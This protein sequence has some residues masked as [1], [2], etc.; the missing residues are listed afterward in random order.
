MP[1]NI[2]VLTMT[3][4][5]HD[6]ILGQV[7]GLSVGSVPPALHCVVSMGDRDLT[8]GRLPLATDRWET[9]VRPVPTDRRALPYAAARN[10]AAKEAIERGAEVLVFLDGG[11]IPGGR[12]LERYA[13]A[14]Q[15]HNGAQVRESTDGPIV[16]CGPV[17]NLPAPDSMAVGYPM[18]QLHTLGVRTPGTPQLDAGQVALAEH[19]E[20]FHGAAFAM[21]AQDFTLSGG[22]HPDYAGHGLE[23]ADFAQTVLDAGGALAWLG[24]ATAYLQ[25]T[26]PP[27]RAEEARIAVNHARIWRERWGTDPAHPWLA[28][29]VGEGA[30]RRDREGG[31]EAA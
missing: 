10:L 16:W 11:A 21:S 3:R 6:Q 1:G 17:L 24:G 29:L 31:F 2:A 26:D 28:R 25:P 15:G 7:D 30:L 14:V 23:D 9:V 22:F 18:G 13:A 8:R 20:L 27:T 4:H 12:T 19:A 5:H